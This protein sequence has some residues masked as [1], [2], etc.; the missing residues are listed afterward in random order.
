MARAS[1]RRASNIVR[2]RAVRDP[3]RRFLI[4]CEGTNAEP[5]YLRALGRVSNTVIEILEGS[6]TPEVIA[7]IAIEKAK[8]LGVI[9]KARAGLA[10][11]ERADEVWAVF[12]RDEHHH[13]EEGVRLCRENCIGVGRS[14]PCFEV[15]LILHFEDFHRPDARDQVLA[16]LCGLC[17]EYKVGKGREVHFDAILRNLEAAER[18][19]EEQCAAR[20]A[21]GGRIRGSFHYYVRLNKKHLEETAAVEP[22]LCDV[23]W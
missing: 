4:V 6:G 20:R 12:D 9:G 14:N 23:L 13:F 15:W 1:R 22:V 8:Q 16:R 17:P 3:K 11:Y 2:R 19:A 10:W 21:E 5:L 7:K 18:R